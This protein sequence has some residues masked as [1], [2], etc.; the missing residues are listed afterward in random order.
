MHL[1][2]S[3]DKPIEHTEIHVPQIC[4]PQGSPN[5]ALLLHTEK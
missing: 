3:Y 4:L 2:Q 1:R 5:G